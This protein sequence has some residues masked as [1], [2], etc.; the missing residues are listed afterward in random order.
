MRRLIERLATLTESERKRVKDEFLATLRRAEI[1]AKSR[2]DLRASVNQRI[3]ET[4][5]HI[6]KSEKILKESKPRVF[7]TA[8]CDE[9]DKSRDSRHK[10]KIWKLP[11]PDLSVG[12]LLSGSLACKFAKSVAEWLST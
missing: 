11:K 12:W 8:G 10:S 5:E 9:N 1:L 2:N 4:A 7:V 3:R 6:V